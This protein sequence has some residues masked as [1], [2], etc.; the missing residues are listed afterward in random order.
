MS[1]TSKNLMEVY[2]QVVVLGLKSEFGL[3]NNLAVPRLIKVVI[4]VGLNASKKIPKR[5][6]W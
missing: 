6:K 3:T 4:N 5:K 1:Q 2:K